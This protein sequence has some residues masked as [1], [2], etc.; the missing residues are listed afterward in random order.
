MASLRLLTSAGC[1]TA[2]QRLQLAAPLATP[3][4]IALTTLKSSTPWLVRFS[5]NTVLLV[6]Q[7]GAG[8]CACP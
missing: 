6:L 8:G 4:F 5:L 7:V 3:G 2:H 1:L